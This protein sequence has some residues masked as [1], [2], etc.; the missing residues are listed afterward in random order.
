ML[1][2]TIKIQQLSVKKEKKIII[3]AS[4]NK[5]FLNSICDKIITFENGKILKQ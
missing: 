2:S 1:N 5:I 3:I 4:H